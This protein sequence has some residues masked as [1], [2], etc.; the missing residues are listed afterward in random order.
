MNHEAAGGSADERQYIFERNLLSLSRYDPELCSRLT[1]SES[2]RGCYKILESRAGIPVPAVVDPSGKSHPLH[3]IVDPV[4]E[5]S[6]LIS[7][8]EDEGFLVFLG[9]GGGYHIEAALG[10]RNI[11]HLLIIDYNIH[12]MTE[13]LASKDY[14]PIFNDSRVRLMIDPS[15][16]TVEQYILD[17]YKPVLF[18][19]IRV[20]PLRTRV[21]FDQ[22]NFAETVEAIKKAVDG[23]SADYSVQ[24]FFGK[25]WLSNILRNIH[26]AEGRQELFPGIKRAA[27]IAAGPSLEAQLPELHENRKNLFILAADTAI[28]VLVS[29]GITPDAAVSIDC[30]HI[31]YYHFMGGIPRDM[32]LF[33]DIASPP[34]LSSLSGNVRFF[35]SGHPL[36][37]YVSRHWRSLP[38]IDTSGGNVTYAAVSLADY[39]GASEIFLYGADFSYP[40][41]K[42]YARGTYIY[43]YFDI[44][45]NRFSPEESLFSAFLY[46]NT[47][48]EKTAA[49]DSWYYETP[50]LRMYRE[51][52]EAKALR[53]AARL[54]SVPGMGAPVRPVRSAPEVP[55]GNSIHTFAAGPARM[56]AGEFLD[57]YREA[58]LALPPITGEIAGNLSLLPESGLEILLTLLPAGAAMKR[59][60]PDWDT[61][62]L[63]SAVKQETD[64]IIRRITAPRG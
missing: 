59:R 36:A 13:L 12:S 24:A 6:R 54:K 22:Q 40:R 46:R 30:Q 38:A 25:R 32:P 21:E 50:T 26:N 61:E 45:Q 48:L 58:V 52:L 62:R 19:G 17:R 41:G 28:P 7:T 23:V 2:T 60:H 16:E 1:V 53:M 20:M 15:P 64:G 9:L 37:R 3:S 31:S 14:V 44:R 49:G 8:L 35:S 57:H 56:S 47:S 55:G 33:L 51:R 27:V 43:P 39:L 63:F 4:R 34:L 18:G 11:R 5:G 10:Q 29:A 42:T